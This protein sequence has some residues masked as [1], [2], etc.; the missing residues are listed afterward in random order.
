MKNI[1]A[2]ISIFSFGL[3]SC[4]RANE[5]LTNSKEILVSPTDSS[6]PLDLLFSDWEL[7]RLTNIDAISSVY[8]IVS[9]IDGEMY[10]LDGTRSKIY[11][12]D[13][14]G[15]NKIIVDSKGEGPGEYH[16]VWAFRVFPESGDLLLL[17]RRSLKLL[18]FSKQGTFL[19]EYP[20][21]K[22]HSSSVLGFEI[23]SENEV[24]F[25]TDGTSGYHFMKFSLFNGNFTL[26][27][28]IDPLLNGFSFG[29]DKSFTTVSQNFSMIHSLGNK[30]K[31]FDAEFNPLED[32]ILDIGDFAITTSELEFMEND[33]IRMLDLILND[34]NRK[35]HSFWL[36][37]TENFYFLTLLLGSYQ[38]GLFFKSI[39]DKES[40]KSTS[41]RSFRV[42]AI[43]IDLIPVGRLNGDRVV[44]KLNL[45][46]LESM[47]L[48]KP[49]SD[50]LDV[51]L[52][53]ESTVLIVGRLRRI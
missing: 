32:V 17:D 33:Q 49:I 5:Q 6:L 3:F 42:G 19:S 52:A 26:F 50:I 43:D 4:D 31:R 34:E 18:R 35:A 7:L 48:E 47:E 44:F 36:E 22:E 10:L 45:E 9:V 25:N 23:L 12:W 29:N 46:Q 1:I 8:R 39:I 51:D 30:I 11:K 14:Q 21:K 15:S 40:F 53:K 16:S 24:V 27:E 13:Q 41:F 38:N 37:E 20:I 2:V 28:P